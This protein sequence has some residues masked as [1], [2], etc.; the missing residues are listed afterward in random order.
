MNVI[1]TI[2]MTQFLK[3][4]VREDIID[5]ALHE[6]AAHGYSGANIA[7]IAKRS[8]IS[9][10][11]VYRYFANKSELFYAAVPN[12]FVK[13]LLSKFK[14]RI[15]AYPIGTKPEDIPENSQY[16]ILFEELLAF[17]IANRLRV[18]IVLEGADG[19]PHESFHVKLK[20]LFTKN[21]VLLLNLSKL[22][23]NS[24]ILFVLLD[25]LYI[26]FIRS[27]ASILRQFP[28]EAD[29]RTA[30]GIYAKYHLERRLFLYRS[31]DSRPISLYSLWQKSLDCWHAI[32]STNYQRRFYRRILHK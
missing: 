13:D 12:S 21:W 19:A 10:G 11:N 22:T 15:E 4:H 27:S 1:F 28:N 9:T 26:N 6:F 3:D 5:A 8:G 31:R 7:D 23:D 32:R 20:A 29:Y 25:N 16:F 30:I 2:I 24:D 14:K 17:T 18:L